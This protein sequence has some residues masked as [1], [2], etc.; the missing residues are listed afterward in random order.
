MQTPQITQTQRATTQFAM[1]ID[2]F[3]NLSKASLHQKRDVRRY[4]YTLET[5]PSHS[6]S[7]RHHRYKKRLYTSTVDTCFRVPKSP[8]P[9]YDVPS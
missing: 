9:N 3:A 8:N 5:T 7:F 1:N 6:F 2:S 4:I